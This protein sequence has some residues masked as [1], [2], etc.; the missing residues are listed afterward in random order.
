MKSEAGNA[1]F[2]IL[3]AVALF[4]ALSYAVT[5]SGR[6]GGGIDKEQYSIIA[7]RMV[8]HFGSMEQA[9]NRMKIINGCSDEEISFE[10]APFDGT[11]TARDN[12]VTGDNYECFI[13]HSDGGGVAEVEFADFFGSSATNSYY[14]GI[15]NS[16]I[17][18]VGTTDAT[19]NSADLYFMVELPPEI[20]R[21]DFCNV[22]NSGLGISAAPVDAIYGSPAFVGTYGTNAPS[23]NT[24]GGAG[25]VNGEYTACIVY[26]ADT[27]RHLIYY[28]LIAR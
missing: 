3:I 27:A 5:S 4:A 16:A 8:Q 15:G 13:Y 7:A 19:T 20:D 12:P 28:V 26:S 14:D 22:Y 9:I 25:A 11:D 6:G 10:H 1:L 24:T 18:G 21:S 2:L 17:I 23:H